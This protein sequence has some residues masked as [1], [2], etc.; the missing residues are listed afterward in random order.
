MITIDEMRSAIFNYLHSM[1]I[2]ISFKKKR[3]T[4]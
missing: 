2:T 1:Y 4:V 3:F